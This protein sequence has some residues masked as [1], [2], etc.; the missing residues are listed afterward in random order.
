MSFSLTAI[1]CYALAGSPKCSVRQSRVRV[2]QR[3]PLLVVYWSQDWLVVTGFCLVQDF[4]RSLC[5]TDCVYKSLCN[6]ITNY[7]ICCQIIK[8]F[9]SMASGSLFDV[10]DIVGGRLAFKRRELFLHPPVEDRGGLR[11]R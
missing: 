6:L 11:S 9:S 3:A 2:G 7:N 4:L 10:Q 5:D 8:L 1:I